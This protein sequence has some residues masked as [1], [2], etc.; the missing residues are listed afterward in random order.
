M[1]NFKGNTT[2]SLEIKNAEDDSIKKI[3]EKI[4]D[5]KFI[6]VKSKDGSQLLMNLYC[7]INIS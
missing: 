2:L 7:E 6:D 4:P 3:T 1:S 5:L